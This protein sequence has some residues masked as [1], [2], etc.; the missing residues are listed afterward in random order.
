MVPLAYVIVSLVL[1]SALV[2]A[3]AII[4]VLWLATTAEHPDRPGEENGSG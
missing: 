1:V 2:L 3:F 4:G